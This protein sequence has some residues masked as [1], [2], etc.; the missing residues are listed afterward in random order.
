M[1][2]AFGTISLS[3]SNCFAE[4]PDPSPPKPVTFPPG[5]AKLATSPDPTGSP[6]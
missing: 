1:R 5:R 4:P 2:D 6:T 3:S